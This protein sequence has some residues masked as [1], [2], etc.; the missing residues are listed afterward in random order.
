MPVNQ[1]DLAELIRLLV[2]IVG[3][4]IAW[5]GGKFLMTRWERRKTEAETKMREHESDKAASATANEFAGL[6][7]DTAVTNRGLM[8]EINTMRTEMLLQSKRLYEL[9]QRVGRLDAENLLLKEDSINQQTWIQHLERGI[10]VL[11]EQMRQAG[12]TPIWTIDTEK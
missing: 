1:T 12:I 9:E 5:F 6:A 4:V 10:G 8:S 7:K 11:S 3:P 2:T